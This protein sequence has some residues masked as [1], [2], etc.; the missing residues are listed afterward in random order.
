MTLPWA[1]DFPP[2]PEFPRPGGGLCRAALRP[3]GLTDRLKYPSRLS[4][5][6]VDFDPTFA[7]LPGTKRK[8]AAL[9]KANPYEPVPEATIPE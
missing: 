8:P 7:I 3:R 4:W 6:M 9:A 2:S 1:G 5:T